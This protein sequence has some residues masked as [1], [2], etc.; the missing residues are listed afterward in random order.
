MF[1]C[2][3]RFVFSKIS[4]VNYLYRGE[5]LDQWQ[6]CQDTCIPNQ[7]DWIP[8]PAL[9]L[10]QPQPLRAGIWEIKYGMGF[11]SPAPFSLPSFSLTQITYQLDYFTFIH[12]RTSLYIWLGI[13]Q[14]N[15]LQIFFQL[16]AFHFL[17]VSKKRKTKILINSN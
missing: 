17:N 12:Y 6:R 16:K 13:H 10:D 1:L 2:P 15:D 14:I 9:A 8:Y 4:I 3:Q 7:T 11:S 5:C